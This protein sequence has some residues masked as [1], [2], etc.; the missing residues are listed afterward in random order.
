MCVLWTMLTEA[1]RRMSPPWGL[2][3]ALEDI[4]GSCSGLS[5]IVIKL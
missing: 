2:G 3:L 5:A 1:R 4:L